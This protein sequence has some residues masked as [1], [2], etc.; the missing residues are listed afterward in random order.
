MRNI[1]IRGM[2]AT[3]A[4]LLVLIVGAFV[5]V[6][7]FNSP[8]PVPRLMAGDTL[9]GMSQWNRAEI[10]DVQQVKARDGAPLTYRLYPGAKDRIVVLVHG[11]SG[12]SI[13]MHKLAEAL[14]AAGATVYS[15]SLRGHGGSG[16]TNGDTSYRGQL[17]DDL[18]DFVKAAGIGAP[19][20]HRSL[21][22]FSS[23]GGFVL[24]QA[25]G[26]NGT[27]FDDYIAISPYIAYDS[28]TTRPAGGG[29]ASVAVPR[30]IAL[31]LLDEFGLPWFQG[32]PVVRFATDAQPSESR[33]PVYSWRLQTGM[34]LDR[35]WRAE[36]A[37]ID[38]PTMVVVGSKDELFHADDFEPLFGGLNHRI[39]VSV[40]P[41]LGHMDM[42]TS[43]RACAAIAAA[44]QRLAGVQRAERFDFKVREDFFAGLDGDKEAFDRAMKEIADTLSANPDHAQAL[45]WRGDGRLFLA[46]Q[47]FQKGDIAQGRALAA[48]GL[49]DMTRAVS[50]DP[51]NVA[52]RVPRATGLLPYAQG[53]RP[54]DAAA[55]D[56]L[57]ALAMEDFEF[58]V[59]ASGNAWSGMAEHNRGELLGALASGWLQL[60]NTAKANAYL[61]RMVAELPGTPYAKAAELRRAQ[62]SA[63]ASL[64]CLSCH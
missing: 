52:V 21:I 43:P 46:G 28:P 15:I 18:A 58:V 33:T 44:W 60:G 35:N 14:R 25:S 40:Q 64:T 2:V 61:D 24:R 38:R 45:V 5:A 9:P 22:G 1:W 3:L 54:F 41:G 6:I 4:T 16:M 10:P 39:S 20:I 26:R 59:A 27:L 42:I 57:T 51:K 47:A 23:G 30:L 31:S 55:A 36:I 53:L 12:A 32:L 48:Q 7:A 11:S 37:R 19:A 50:L 49:D 63:K 34:H 8:A 29:W 17:D 62:P 13:S 56:R